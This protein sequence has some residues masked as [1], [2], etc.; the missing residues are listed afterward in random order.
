MPIRLSIPWTKSTTRRHAAACSSFQIPTSSGLIRPSGETAAASVMMR[1]ARPMANE[2]RRT[3][4]QSL[5]MPSTDEYWHMGATHSRWG[6]VSPFR[7]M[8]SNRRGF[9]RGT[10]VPSIVRWGVDGSLVGAPAT[11]EGE[12]AA[13]HRRRLE[14]LRQVILDE[15]LDRHARRRHRDVH[16]AD[17]SSVRTD[18]GGGDGSGAEVD[19]LVVEGP[20]LR[21]HFGDAVAELVLVDDGR[22]RKLLA[23]VGAEV[24]VEAGIV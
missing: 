12:V 2:P 5:G 14:Q 22:R 16:G 13:D 10:R 15:L 9:R 24:L 1:P 4:C 3:R 7:V 23:R 11:E 18:H 8:G 21:A 17:V 19:L 20:A 6:M